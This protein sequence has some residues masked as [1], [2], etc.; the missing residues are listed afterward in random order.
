MEVRV[1]KEHNVE[2]EKQRRI[3]QQIRSTERRK[4]MSP[5]KSPSVR[6]FTA[7]SRST[8]RRWGGLSSTSSEADQEE[9]EVKI[10]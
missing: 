10:F 1:R 2:M 9:E 7:S 6:L 5:P 3:Q 4:T 8:P